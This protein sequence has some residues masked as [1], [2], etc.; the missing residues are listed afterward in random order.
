MLKD[1]LARQLLAILFAS[2]EPVELSDLEVVFPDVSPVDLESAIETLIRD[3]NSLL[4]CLEIRR[5]AGGLRITTLAEYHQIVH[6]YLKTKPSAKLSLA[7]LETLAVIAYKQ[8]VTLP[9][10]MEIRGIK[11]TSTN[12]TLLEKGLIETRGRKKVVGRPIRYGT[13]REFLV[14]FGLGDLKDLP[15]LEEFQ[16]ILDNSD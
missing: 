10:I 4:P 8:P 12:R 13:T 9:E 1:E 16:E 2:R 5:I 15:T 7:A 6:A 3:F 11:S 14:H